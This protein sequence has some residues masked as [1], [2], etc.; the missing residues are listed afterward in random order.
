MTRYQ[1]VK[2]DYDIGIDEGMEYTTIQEAI[3]EAK[4]LLKEYHSIFIYDKV[5]ISC[6]HAF[7][8]LPDHVFNNDIDIA[9]TIYHWRQS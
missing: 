6:R 8:G 3:I 9:H 5:K 1:I 7:N 2:Y 4:K